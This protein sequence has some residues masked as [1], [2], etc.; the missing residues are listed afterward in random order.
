MIDSGVTHLYKMLGVTSWATKF[1]GFVEGLR[2]LVSASEML[3][4][5]RVGSS[6]GTQGKRDLERL[7]HT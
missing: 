3:Q 2:Q 7:T 6:R 1:V 5:D 4:R